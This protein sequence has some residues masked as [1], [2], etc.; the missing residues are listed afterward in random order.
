[1]A[2]RL[3][4]LHMQYMFLQTASNKIVLT[5][6]KT[7]PGRNAAEAKEWKAADGGQKRVLHQQPK[8]VT[9]TKY[10]KKI[11]KSALVC[12]GHISWIFSVR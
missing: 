5:W 9:K 4:D 6:C 1:M 11:V 7:Q 3:L 12:F 8:S 2:E 10:K